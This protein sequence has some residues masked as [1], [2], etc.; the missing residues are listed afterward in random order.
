MNPGPKPPFTGR[1]FC[2]AVRYACDAAPLWSAFCH[3]ESCRRATSS[4]I[5]AFF[6]MAD[7]HWRWTGAAPA[8]FA[9]SPGVWRDFC[10]TCGAQM[11]YRSTRFPDEIHFYAASLDDPAAYAPE[12]HVFTAEA[13][14]W[15]HLADGLPQRP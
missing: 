9:S 15:I 11:S 2:G 14:P 12:N 10:P 4:P 8:T 1:C 7:G 6:G 3:C 5:T 13:L